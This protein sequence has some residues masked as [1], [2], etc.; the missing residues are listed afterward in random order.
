MGNQEFTVGIGGAAG[1]GIASTENVL[2]RTS[3]RLGLH[4][5]AYNS[6][7]SVIRGGH[8]WLRM[9]GSEVERQSHG[10]HLT[11]LIALNQDTLD[12]HAGEVDEGGYILYNGDKLSMDGL[13]TKKDVDVI[14][15]PI[16]EI[17][18][19][20][21][22]KPLMQN[23]VALGA[24]VR[25]LKLDI[26]VVDGVL[27]EIF[28]HKGDK[29]IQANQSLARAGYD[30]VEGKASPIPFDWEFTRRA[31]PVITGNEAIAMGAA[32]AGCKFYS[33]YP[34]T[35]ASSILHWFATHAEQLGVVVKQ[36][37][38][39]LAVA[40][41]AIGA[42]F[43][44]VRSMCAT[45]GGGFALMTE[46][47]GMAGIMEIPVVFVEV[48]RGGPSTGL[49][50]KT[51]QGDLNQV[52]G[53]S[54]G[55]YPRIIVAP[56]TM[57]E[58]FDTTGEA[59]NLAEK[60]QLPVFI[61][62]DLYLSEHDET[63]DPDL[64][65]FEMEIDRG[66]IATEPGEGYERFAQTETGVSPRAFPGTPGGVHVA[67]SDEHNEK[68][69]LIS[70]VNTD[71]ATRIRMM[72]KRMRKMVHAKADLPPPELW[73]PADAD[74]TLIGWGSTQ[75]VIREAIELLEKDGIRCNNLQIKY[76]HPFHGDEVTAILQA[77][78]KTVMVEVNY[79]GQFERHLRAETGLSVDAH[80]RKYDGEPMEPLYI[81]EH[82]KEIQG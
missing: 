15:L 65:D 64:F 35:P 82:V 32:A 37:E 77:A 58:A 59:F 7:Q 6:Y 45:S 3:A 1:D 78:K 43:A 17:S 34:M 19:P 39:E 24:A 41:M 62:S 71:P 5:C 27:G 13:E 8:I 20:F 48:Q 81:V 31:R 46:A 4:I 49:P 40:N 68:G 61:M 50:T 69:E 10:D 56:R 42:G 9:R 23:T 74:V 18:D 36:A 73:G 29:V 54:Q 47:C 11:V 38:D 12:R 14:P 60:Y 25:L 22:G 21:G 33:A 51:E 76:I 16:K 44:G 30:H 63:V 67:G 55:D 75:G 52:Y 26:E 57:I 70:D 28:G 66:A 72:D 79:T 53:A 80:I 2:A